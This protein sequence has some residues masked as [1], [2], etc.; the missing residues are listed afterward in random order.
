MFSQNAVEADNL[1]LLFDLVEDVIC[2]L[3]QA[4][5]D[6]GM[7]MS[8]KKKKKSKKEIEYKKIVFGYRFIESK[9]KGQ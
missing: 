2:C 9:N 8:N 7:M 4:W 1:T 5:T 3:R 6:S